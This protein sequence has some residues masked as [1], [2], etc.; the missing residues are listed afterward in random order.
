MKKE[1]TC[2]VCPMGCELSVNYDENNNKF[3]ICGNKCNKGIE[4]AKSEL[5]NPVRMLT[6][7]IKVDNKY[8]NTLC[9]KTDKAIPK[10]KIFEA[11]KIIKKLKVDGEIKVGDI[12]IE[13]ILDTGSNIVATSN[14]EI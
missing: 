1:L 6:T 4:Y 13:N 12:L 7:T 9:V 11:L 10:G 8:K 3:E 14:L 5:T 2:I